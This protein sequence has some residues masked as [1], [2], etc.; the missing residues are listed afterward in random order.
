MKKEETKKRQPTLAGIR[1]VDI[2]CN[3][4][5]LVAFCTPGLLAWMGSSHATGLMLPGWSLVVLCGCSLVLLAIG[6][7]EDARADA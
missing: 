3:P 6:T 2:F 5:V 1:W 7:A 4:F